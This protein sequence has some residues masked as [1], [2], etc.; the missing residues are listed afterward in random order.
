MLELVE[1]LAIST[2][3]A[4]NDPQHAGMITNLKSCSSQISTQKTSWLPPIPSTTFFLL[5][6]DLSLRTI[7]MFIMFRDACIGRN[8]ST[9]ARTQLRLERKGCPQGH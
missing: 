6:F 7:V 1:P 4:I 5:A 2:C 3:N 8:I 9:S